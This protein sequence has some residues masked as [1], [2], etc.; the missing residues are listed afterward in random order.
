MTD[1]LDHFEDDDVVVR[2]YLLTQG[3]TR[4]TLPIE[5]VVATAR[6]LSESGRLSSEARDILALCT[7]PSA[8]A[9]VSAH[10]RIPLGVARILVADLVDAGWLGRSEVVG[11]HPD[12]SLVERLISGLRALA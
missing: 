6:P 3:R 8:V 10:L 7:V 1:G 9:E 11:D 4:S 12:I 2:P 5:T